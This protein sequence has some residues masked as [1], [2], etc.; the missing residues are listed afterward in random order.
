MFVKLVDYCSLFCVRFIP[1]DELAPSTHLL[2]RQLDQF[3]IQNPHLY[4]CVALVLV[5]VGMGWRGLCLSINRVPLLSRRPP[6]A[7]L[8]ALWLDQ[9][10]NPRLYLLVRETL[11]RSSSL[12]DWSCQSAKRLPLLHLYVLVD[13]ISLKF[14]FKIRIAP[15]LAQIQKLDATRFASLYTVVPPVLVL[16]SR[17]CI[18]M[19]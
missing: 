17:L 5:C 15:L 3:Q 4:L 7:L 2:A 19:D 13:Q 14:K 12:C 11:Y 10:Q 6:S 16:V 18:G 8:L 9:I 1:C